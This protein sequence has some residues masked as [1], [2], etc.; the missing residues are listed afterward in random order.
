MELLENPTF[1]TKYLKNK[2]RV[3]LWESDFMEKYGRKPNKVSYFSRA[4]VFI[5][6][7]VLTKAI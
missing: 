6:Y 2:L 5:A 3:K 4:V 1:K 7:F